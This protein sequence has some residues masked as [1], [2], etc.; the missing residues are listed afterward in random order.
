MTYKLLLVQLLLIPLLSE[1]KGQGNFGL[2][3]DN[4]SSA[5]NHYDSI[6]VYHIDN[7]NYFSSYK[8]TE[9]G[10]HCYKGNFERVKELVE[11]GADIE[12]GMSN[13]Y[14]VYG[15]I[16]PAII[17]ENI[18]IVKYLLDKGSEVNVISSESGITPI[19]TATEIKS[20]KKSYQ[21][22]KLLLDY[23]ANPNGGGRLGFYNI[24]TAYPIIEAIKNGNAE[25]VKLLIESEVCIVIDGE[26]RN[27][28]FNAAMDLENEDIVV[29]IASLLLKT[30]TFN[31]KNNLIELSKESERK[32]KS[33]LTELI[34]DYIRTLYS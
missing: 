22:T 20:S 33:R 18:E 16:H 15:A 27:F 7:H 5:K 24:T 23:G 10:Y 12:Q 28:V 32:G 17:S 8:F 13:D 25:T 14:F 3:D 30:N 1:V 9:L 34:N 29:E 31:N 26:P 4:Y 6:Y 11:D 2:V 19:T 21:I